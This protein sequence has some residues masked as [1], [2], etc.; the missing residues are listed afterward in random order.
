MS[1]PPSSDVVYGLITAGVS[2]VVVLSTRAMDS[3]TH[4][5]RLQTRESTGERQVLLGE[6]HN[7]RDSLRE[8]VTRCQEEREDQR[9]RLESFGQRIDRLEAEL[10]AQRNAN[11]TLR[12]KLMESGISLDTNN[13][14]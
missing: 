5:A 10:S 13:K 1:G 9:L 6:W 3:R 2:A 12:R 8:E 14:E 11:D 4:R 7:I